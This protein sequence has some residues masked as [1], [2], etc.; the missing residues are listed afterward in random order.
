[1]IAVPSVSKRVHLRPSE[2]LRLG[3]LTFP[4]LNTGLF[5]NQHP[6]RDF[7]ETVKVKEYFHPLNNSS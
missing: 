5:S 2:H 6:T 4:A 3:L 7:I 1:M